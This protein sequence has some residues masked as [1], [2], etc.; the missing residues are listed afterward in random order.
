MS[1]ANSLDSRLK[2]AEAAGFDTSKI[3]Y[4][5][6]IRDL[7]ALGVNPIFWA[8][9]TPSLANE[10][11]TAGQLAIDR[12]DALQE[13]DLA[14]NVIPVYVRSR[15]P[16]HF[17]HA[18]QEVTV[19]DIMVGAMSQA[20]R[21]QNT[22]RAHELFDLLDDKYGDRRQPM[23]SFWRDD[24]AVG[25]FLRELGFDSIRVYE[26]ADRQNAT[27]GSLY[28][29]NVRSINAS[30]DPANDTGRH[31]LF[32]RFHDKEPVGSADPGTVYLRDND[33]AHAQ[34]L[35]A[36]MVAFGLPEH[37]RHAYESVVLPSHMYPLATA[38]ESAFGRRVVAVRPTGDDYCA[39]NG[40]YDPE[41]PTK[42]FVNVH[43]DAGFVQ[44][45]GHELLHGLR[46][47][48]PALYQ[49]FVNQ[50]RPYLQG[51]ESFEKRLNSV[52]LPEESGY[53]TD[54][55]VEELIADIAGDALADR[56]F[57][58]ELADDSPK[59][60][61]KLA[62]AVDGWADRTGHLVTGLDS[63]A[64][65]ADLEVLRRHL[66]IALVAYAENRPIEDLLSR[67]GTLLPIGLEEAGTIGARGP[68]GLDSVADPVA[69]EWQSGIDL[70]LDMSEAA[71]LARAAQMGFDTSRVWY[72]GTEQS[73]FSA[74]SHD[75]V[76]S[77]SKNCE[78]GFYFTENE[79]NAATYAGPRRRA[80]I[81]ADIG[82]LDEEGYEIE[83]DPTPG[84]YPV[85]LRMGKTLDVDFEGRDWQGMD[86]TGEWTGEWSVPEVE[87]FAHTHGYDSVIIHNVLDEGPH[88]QGYHWGSTTVIVFDPS[89]IRSVDAA[90]N[91][92]YQESA[93]LL[94]SR[95]QAATIPTDD[96]LDV[97]S[98]DERLT[99]ARAM[100]FDTS[101]VL[102]HQTSSDYVDSIFEEGFDLSPE[103]AF[104]RRSDG[105]VPD[106]VFLKSHPGDI[107]I[108]GDGSAET[109]SIPVYAAISNPL[110]IADRAE[111]K[112]FL[113]HHNDRYKA[114]LVS[115]EEIDKSYD[116]QVEDIWQ[117]MLDLTRSG[118]DLAAADAKFDS[119]MAE[120]KTRI[121]EIAALSRW[122]ATQTLRQ[123]GY[124]SVEMAED[125]GTLGRATDAIMVLD[126]HNIRSIEAD[127]APEKAGKPQLM[128]SRR[129]NASPKNTPP[130]HGAAPEKCTFLGTFEGR[131]L[132]Y[133]HTEIPCLA[134]R[135]GPN[136]G[137]ISRLPVTVAS[138]LEANQ[139]LETRFCAALD[140]AREKGVIS[141]GITAAPEQPDPRLAR[142]GLLRNEQGEPLLLYRGEHGQSGPN[143]GTHTREPSITYSSREAAEIYARSPNCRG[144]RVIDP[145]VTSAHLIIDKPFLNDPD[146]PFVDFSV[147][148]DA[149]GE[150]V[151]I[152]A[153][154]DHSGHV[155]STN[156]WYEVCGGYKDVSDMLAHE[157][158]KLWQL[159][160]DAYPI[161]ADPKVVGALSKAGYDG[162]IHS[163]N[164]VTA[165]EPEYKVFSPQQIIPV[166]HERLSHPTPEPTALSR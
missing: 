124:D 96:R 158:E 54:Q 64:Y 155:L 56:A 51:I 91:P 136:A 23:H 101:R 151:A 127:F 123:L 22:S 44:L 20:G 6:T 81:Q 2:R 146:D 35:N 19:R 92:A 99:R 113:S 156:N 72:H 21:L 108:G 160:V 53:S 119:M 154:R 159:Y 15:K 141:P 153:A 68:P 150:E 67:D 25:D 98:P 82:K 77:S 139:S 17:R 34:Q 117:E 66:R 32:K 76:G 115:G 137:D 107:G 152:Q 26:R 52:L 163:G 164:G 63:D 12:S 16:V 126:P 60:F 162:A 13:A 83:L 74:F 38:F 80:E 48:R 111:L 130:L 94:F 147:I 97:I 128:F 14:S 157:P 85:Y 3:W 120:W 112:A 58:R 135:S 71:R 61:T 45:A 149:V 93:E 145:V 114:L 50:A 39:F 89:Q 129:K 122:E 9:E 88:G 73:G 18:E 24:Y 104:A 41:D 31:L 105:D 84:I 70:G 95:R 109:V 28:P 36:A 132:F 33:Q 110:R 75:K 102:Y 165:E 69:A 100:G 30:F 161:L 42:V 118:G 148:R 65:V 57:L 59:K 49:W 40:I 78:Q 43:G 7:S 87:A 5:G 8:S 79:A 125:R 144:E 166:K 90:F 27:I 4:H 37:W 46:R 1:E 116:A 103:R 133:Q 142:P 55:A 134:V 11:A 10:Y 140:A 29:Q 143:K 138:R 121:R 47:D 131:D 62:A 86:E 106:A